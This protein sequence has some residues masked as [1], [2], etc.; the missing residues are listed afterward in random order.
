MR[1]Q[2]V[3][4]GKPQETSRLNRLV[5]GVLLIWLATSVL[6]LVLYRPDHAHAVQPS[7]SQQQKFASVAPQAVGASFT[8]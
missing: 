7:A 6:L 8:Y 1:L 5:F 2:T 4:K 3:N